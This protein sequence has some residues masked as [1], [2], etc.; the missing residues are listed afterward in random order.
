MSSPDPH[1]NRRVYIEPLAGPPA[2]HVRDMFTYRPPPVV[3]VT[4]APT[5]PVGLPPAVLTVNRDIRPPQ[6]L[7]IWSA[8]LQ[9]GLPRPLLAGATAPVRSWFQSPNIVPRPTYVRPAPLFVPPFQPTPAFQ[10]LA[11]VAQG[12]R[13]SGHSQAMNHSDWRPQGRD[14]V[15]RISL[16][17][18]DM[19]SSE[20]REVVGNR[21]RPGQRHVRQPRW[22]TGIDHPKLD[23][24]TDRMPAAVIPL[25]TRHGSRAESALIS[26]AEAFGRLLGEGETVRAPNS[27][28]AGSQHSRLRDQEFPLLGEG[29]IVDNPG[30]EPGSLRQSDAR[31]G[32]RVGIESAAWI[33]VGRAMTGR[34][35]TLGALISGRLRSTAQEEA[36]KALTGKF[37][38][39]LKSGAS[40][41][42][43]VEGVGFEGV[44]VAVR[45]DELVVSRWGVHNISRIPGQGRLVH[46]AFE[47]AALEAGRQSGQRT[48]RVALEAV[49][50][51]R[52][53]AR[54]EQ[55]GYRYDVIPNDQGGVVRVLTKTF[56]TPLR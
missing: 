51:P 23:Q 16:R 22:P 45:G 26:V 17:P 47:Q 1:P 37:T 18:R 40:E 35:P 4:P 27:P 36:R 52:W 50:N 46:T 29:K 31:Y 14:E 15:P 42:I 56:R 2:A 41:S 54:L 11:P 9:P 6:P 25:P 44:R 13:L 30:G 49:Q 33:A 12:V 19:S 34:S 32:A 5:Y 21:V 24:S 3:P 48:V 20:S 7:P 43:S 10:R 55:E 39:L 28:E 53:A 8:P 38:E